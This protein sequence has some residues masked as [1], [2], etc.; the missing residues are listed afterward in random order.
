[1]TRIRAQRPAA[2][3]LAEIEATLDAVTT[4][5]ADW[6][7]SGTRA[8]REDA[9]WELDDTA[10]RWRADGEQPAAPS[11]P[12]TTGSTITWDDVVRRWRSPLLDP[13]PVRFETC[14]PSDPSRRSHL[15][16]AAADR[17][18]RDEVADAID[19]WQSPPVFRYEP[20]EFPTAEQVTAAIGRMFQPRREPLSHPRLFREADSVR[21]LETHPLTRPV[22]I[23]VVGRHPWDVDR[24]CDQ[25]NIPGRLRRQQI[26]GIT[27]VPDLRVLMGMIAQA[28]IVLDTFAG[29]PQAEEI[30][31]QVVSRLEPAE[32]AIPPWQRGF[33]RQLS[34]AP[35]RKDPSM[36]DEPTP[37]RPAQRLTDEQLVAELVRLADTDE[38]PDRL[39][40]ELNGAL[41]R[42]AGRQFKTAIGQFTAALGGEQTQ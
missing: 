38:L 22:P 8:P 23:V 21:M 28:A 15:R 6:S 16:G 13:L 5:A 19:G 2:D 7:G 39:A 14:D 26:I 42:R 27:C 9:T 11:E 4:P 10:A 34:G 31:A 40:T 32:H 37:L 1:M 18:Y 36:A 25:G 30:L 20:A 24:W 29:H 17:G 12:Q 3:V 35:S 33:L 41:I